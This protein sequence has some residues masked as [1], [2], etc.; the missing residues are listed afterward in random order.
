MTLTDVVS[1][2]ADL[3]AARAALGRNFGLVVV[4]EGLVH[5]I[6]ELHA[7]IAEMNALFAEGLSA[8]AVPARLTPW[9][10]AVLSFLP[11]FFRSQLF[12]E[13]CAPPLALLSAH[14]SSSHSSPLPLLL[15]QRELGRHPAQPGVDGAPPR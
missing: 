9:S 1:E 15:L 10:Q 4:P 5:A 14:L 6:P 13:R 12:L 2:L 11:A 8:E 7:L 3:V